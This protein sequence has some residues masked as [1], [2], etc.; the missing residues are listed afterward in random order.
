M[1]KK[2]S[3]KNFQS[4]KKSD[5]YFSK[6]V[7]YIGGQSDACKSG[8]I[9][10][11]NWVCS[12]KPSGDDFIRHG[13]KETIAVI[14]TEQGE[15]T[16]K[17]GKENIYNLNIIGS[18][19]GEF[20]AFGA[21]VP[22][23]IKDVLNIKDLNFQF[24]HDPPFLFSKSPGEVS[25]YLNKI[26][27]LEKIDSSLQ[28]A[29]SRIKG[30]T[31]DI[32]YQ[33]K[34]LEELKEKK[35]SFDWVDDCE[36]EVDQLIQLESALNQRINESEEL[37]KLL[38]AKQAEENR[39]LSI[40]KKTVLERP[41]DNLLKSADKIKKLE[42]KEQ[43]LVQLI[44]QLQDEYDYIEEYNQ[45]ICVEKEVNNLIEKQHEIFNLLSVEANLNKLIDDFE[46]NDD[47]VNQCEQAVN[48]FQKEYNEL[49]GDEC[50]LCGAEIK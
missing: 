13:S 11:L 8:I 37:E 33:K 23:E 38:D 42:D 28:H 41:V 36:K 14:D 16:R 2:L 27:N 4:H 18:N 26:V 3:L 7:N 19:V 45:S 10:A 49:I 46:I 39:L 48:C 1:L 50:P 20:K 6:G 30:I 17:K 21:G 12:N 9:R 43:K 5:I 32:K 29:N 47:Q 31:T 22:E 40:S 24:Q 15:V 34:E 25:R 35:K 44:Y